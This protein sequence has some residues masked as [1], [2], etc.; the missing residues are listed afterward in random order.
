[1]GYN[2]TVQCA[3]SAHVIKA[4]PKSL[5]LYTMGHGAVPV[6]DGQ[7]VF[8][9]P[10]FVGF[11]A[12]DIL[13]ATSLPAGLR[14]RL[15][16]FNGCESA[17][18]GASSFLQPCGSSCAYVG[19]TGIVRPAFAEPPSESFFHSLASGTTIEN[20][21]VE[22]LTDTTGQ[23]TSALVPANSANGNQTLDMK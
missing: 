3:T 8:Q 16:F 4:L 10:D 17:I 20:A 22:N 14:L 5:I 12:H 19:W 9:G 18:S 21:R 1:M 13:T 7:E 2:E 15:C 11:F 6:I 23:S